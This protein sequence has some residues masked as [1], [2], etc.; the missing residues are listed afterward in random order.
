MLKK[1]AAHALH[2][3]RV[4]ECLEASSNGTGGITPYL[5]SV[6]QNIRNLA[7]KMIWNAH[8]RVV[9]LLANDGTDGVPFLDLQQVGRGMFSDFCPDN[10]VPVANRMNES[11]YRAYPKPPMVRMSTKQYPIGCHSSPLEE[12]DDT[13]GKVF[14]NHVFT[15]TLPTGRATEALSK[16]KGKGRGL[17]GTAVRDD[18]PGSMRGQWLSFPSTSEMSYPPNPREPVAS[19]RPHVAANTHEHHV[20][21]KGENRYAPQTLQDLGDMQIFEGSD[22]MLSQ[23]PVLS[24]NGTEARSTRLEDLVDQYGAAALDSD[25]GAGVASVRGDDIVAEVPSWRTTLL[26]NHKRRLNLPQTF[27]RALP[28]IKQVIQQAVDMGFRCTDQNLQHKIMIIEAKEQLYSPPHSSSVGSAEPVQHNTEL[29]QPSSF[30]RPR[31][32]AVYVVPRRELPGDAPRKRQKTVASHPKV[33][34]ETS[35]K[36]KKVK[37]SSSTQSTASTPSVLQVGVASTDSSV[38]RLSGSA[39]LESHQVLPPDAYFEP[40][41]QDERPAWRCGIKHAMGYYYNAGNRTSCPGCFTNIKDNVSRKI[42]DFYLPLS[43]FSF[44][45]APGIIWRPSKQRDKARRSKTLSHNSI[46]KEAY[47][48]AFNTTKNAKIAL[49]TLR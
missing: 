20:D 47:W 11:W 27:R 25:R 6:S 18:V 45:P 15:S 35:K 19:N 48:P 5:R 36:N 3:D 42:M 4:A 26:N 43:S 14:N 41:S 29:S 23:P 28:G 12:I 21:N 44:Q 9:N 1:F 31:L 38:P 46:A 16:K 17:P 13:A 37:T 10:L 40:Q 7:D 32:D 24:N 34:R 49:S 2:P 8:C 39:T 30:V 33:N 22:Y